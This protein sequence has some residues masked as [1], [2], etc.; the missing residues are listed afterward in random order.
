MRVAANAELGRGSEPVSQLTAA[1]RDRSDRSRSIYSPPA[2]RP[3]DHRL[4]HQVC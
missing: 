3:D 1:L 2:G 4:Q